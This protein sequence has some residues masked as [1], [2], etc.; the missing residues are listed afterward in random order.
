VQWA[1][2]L[3]V[4]TQLTW[5]RVTGILNAAVFAQFKINPERFIARATHRYSMNSVVKILRS[6]RAKAAQH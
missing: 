3:S 6:E 1:V 4:G 5:R 2:K